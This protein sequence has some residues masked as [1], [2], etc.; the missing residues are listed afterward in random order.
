MSKSHNSCT[1]CRK[2]SFR[3]FEHHV[4]CS[5][6]CGHNTKVTE[7]PRAVPGALLRLCTEH[8]KMRLISC[9]HLTLRKKRLLNIFPK[10]LNY[11][12]VKAGGNKSGSS[13]EGRGEDEKVK[14]G[15]KAIEH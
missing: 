13:R 14:K 9:Y 11:F 4:S 1:A 8:I 3:A 15:R 12:N 5:S 6:N 2:K 7:Q 10:K